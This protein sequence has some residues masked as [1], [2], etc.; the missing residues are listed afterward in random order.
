[1]NLNKL[2]NRNNCTCGKAHVCEIES[3]YVETNALSRLTAL[4]SS[5]NKILIV[6][7]ENTYSFAGEKVLN[8][9]DETKVVF[10][11]F[12]SNKQLI[13]NEETV[14]AVN[15][16][17]NQIDLI[18]GVG[19]GVIQD[20]C[21]YVSF[22]N[23]LPYFI[24]PTA[25]SMDGYASSTA[26]MTFNGVKTSTSCRPPKAII[27]D[28]N[29]LKNAPFKM[30]QSGFGDI[31]GKFSALNDWLLAKLIINEYF[32]PFIYRLTYKTL[33]KVAKLS[34]KLKSRD[35]Y[36][37][38]K[39]MEALIVTGICM[40]YM[41][42]SRS[43]S[44]SEHLLSHFFETVGINNNEPY[45]PHGI[46]VAYSTYHTMLMREKLLKLDSFDN[47]INVNR[48]VYEASMHKFYGDS[49][50]TLIKMQDD[51]NKVI[52]VRFN[53]YKNFPLKI[54]KILNKA[55]LNF[56]EFYNNYYA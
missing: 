6:L 31:I 34:N 30:I 11:K 9:L 46:N 33:K 54:K 23:N 15:S 38:K 52:N 51:F 35:G 17:L 25:P 3:I 48:E 39:L 47:P 50:P 5:Y 10:K 43:A 22:T 53:A 16:E 1:M 40:S 7:D 2:L 37:I 49:A 26:I 32:C 27:A 20:V 24:I 28:V 56:L 21:K 36:A 19:S 18:I 41:G 42:N 44:G 13:P 8:Y 55:N 29:L 4:T 45:L 12:P 14:S